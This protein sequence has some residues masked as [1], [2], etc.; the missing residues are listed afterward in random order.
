VEG[1]GAAA[2]VEGSDAVA[3][4]QRLLRINT[5][6]PPGNEEPAQE[7]LAETLT[8]AGFECQFLAAEAGRP[9]LVAR[10]RGEA[11]G[12]S[13]C[14]L[15]HVDTVP[16]DPSEWT[17]DPWSGEV[18][19]GEIR[20]RGAQDMKDQVA[21]EV[22][23]AAGL[24]REGWR[25]SS[26]D[27]LVVAT[28]D[29]E[30]GAEAGAQWLC[31]EH[32]DAVRCDYVLNEGGGVAFEVE[33]RRFYTLCVGEK[34]VFRFLVRTHGR[35]GHAS[36]PALGDN[37]LLKLAPLLER[38]RSQP[39]VEAT[40]EAVEFIY[41]VGGEDPGA[42]PDGLDEA[43]EHLRERAPE[44]VAYLLEPMLRVTLVPTKARASE[45]E[46]VIPSAAETLV[47]CRVP[48]GVTEDEVRRQAEAILGSSSDPAAPASGQGRMT[49]R[50]T[51]SL[52]AEEA[53][54]F[55]IEFVDHVVGNRSP[56]DSGLR[57][58][59]EGWLAEND[60]GATLVPIV[61]AGF[62]DSHWFRKAFDAATVYGFCPQREMSLLEAAPLVH[63]ADERA[64][65]ADIEF[66]ERFYSDV[67]RR[68]LE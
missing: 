65:V 1:E 58:V 34:G 37:A 50:P 33:G 11:P 19:D 27:L 59:I 39:P 26:G 20:G 25:P 54:G 68:V 53:A 8:E 51:G 60:P 32:P 30:M 45:K 52:A 47:D 66:A 18:V 40:S 17:F 23:A 43:V 2:T 44:V 64:A 49:G 22:A 42:D 56:S 35:A 5:V 61:M 13:L 7:L 16:A 67:I 6:N 41:G 46:N 14:L 55:D 38:L 28:A 36:V 31:R 12:K 63:G 4:L 24:G 57:D 3:L 48:P 15:G 62:S 21:A 29:E 9:N 10:L